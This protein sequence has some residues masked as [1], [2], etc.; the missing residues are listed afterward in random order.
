VAI[1][2]TY[3]RLVNGVNGIGHTDA[4]DAFAQIKLMAGT[5]F[6]PELVETFMQMSTEEIARHAATQH[7]TDSIRG[8]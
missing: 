3:D 1:V 8:T 7:D 5:R 6:D 2:D 4:V